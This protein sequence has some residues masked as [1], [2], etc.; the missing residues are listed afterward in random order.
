[1][2]ASAWS[3]N[4]SALCGCGDSSTCCSSSRHVVGAVVEPP[5]R[6][7]PEPALAAEV[8]A[9]STAARVLLPAAHD[10][11]QVPVGAAPGAVQRQRAH[12]R[13]MAQRQLL[14][15]RPAHR[16]A[17]DV[18]ALD[19]ERA[20]QSARPRPRRARSCTARPARR[21]DRHPGCRRRSRGGAR[22]RR[23]SAGPT[24]DGRRRGRRRAARDRPRRA[25]S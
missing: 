16:R 4:A 8:D 5:D 18:S 6:E 3:Q 17:D 2:Q 7:H 21:S 25:A 13:W 19:A 11:R 14:R 1:M 23:P 15:D 24:R 22:G 9:A 12:E 10:R 20:E